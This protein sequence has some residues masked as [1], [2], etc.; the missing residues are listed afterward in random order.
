[1][2]KKA[3]HSLWHNGLNERAKLLALLAFSLWFFF[4]FYIFSGRI[5]LFGLERMPFFERV[6]RSHGEISLLATYLTKGFFILPFFL[7]IIQSFSEILFLAAFLI[8][9]FFMGYLF[10]RTLFFPQKSFEMGEMLPISTGVGLWFFSL[11]A[12]FLTISGLL[13]KGVVIGFVALLLVFFFLY[14]RTQRRRF[15]RL[16]ISPKKRDG[17]EVDSRKAKEGGKGRTHEILSGFDRYLIIMIGLSILL[18]FLFSLRPPIHYDALEYHLAVPSELIKNNSFID[19]PFDVHTNFPLNIEMLYLL[20]LLVS[21]WKLANFMNF[22]FLPLFL[23]LIYSFGKRFFGRRTAIIGAAIFGSTYAIMDLSTHPL[24]DLEF[25]FFTVSSFVLLILWLEKERDA[26]FYL[27]ALLTGIALG[28]KYTALIFTIPLNLLFIILFLFIRKRGW[29][30]K[31][32]RF[33]KDI[34]K[35]ILYILIILAVA[36][37]WLIR[38]YIDTG[39]PVFPI[40]ANMMG[41]KQWTPDQDQLLKK[42]ANRSVM[43]FRGVLT[44]P[45]KM[46]FSERDFGS[47]S[48][49]GPV[50]LIFLPLIFLYRKERLDYILIL[51]SLLYFLLWGLSLNMMRFAVPLL[52]VL[53]ILAGRAIYNY[54]FG[55]RSNLVKVIVI[56]FLV[57]LISMNFLY[58]LVRQIN[59][60]YSARVVLGAETERSFLSKYIEYYSTIEI[61]NSTAGDSSKILF[62]GDPRSFYTKRKAVWSSAYN[63]NPIVTLVREKD[64]SHEISE[65]LLSSG[66]SHILYTPYGIEVLRKNYNAY[67]FHEK[68]IERFHQFLKSETTVLFFDRGVYLLLIKSSP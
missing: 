30:H 14:L 5:S 15:A 55:G 37:P 51:Y 33:G 34:L 11:F 40:A 35:I 8:S 3:H 38:N 7:K 4:L 53:S 19:F 66:F 56:T 63:E 23:I 47:S 10:T 48:F 12:I 60:P 24:V 16:P 32:R 64:T 50:F 52:A 2:K 54:A 61:F 21:G 18:A 42:A 9:S 57:I 39:N 17:E 27:S 31:K 58:F 26:F 20:A 62:V 49:I 25:G 67:P 44:L 41:W 36:S 28:I 65:A 68:E 1:M 59:F 45:W 13:I 29:T 22:A 6:V 46:S 43:D